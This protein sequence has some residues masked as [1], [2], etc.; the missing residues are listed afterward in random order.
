MPPG[1][2]ERAMG[3]DHRLPAWHTPPYRLSTLSG[4]KMNPTMRGTITLHPARRNKELRNREPQ[5]EPLGLKTRDCVLPA[6]FLGLV[7]G[8]SR[9]S[10]A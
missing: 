1:G 2:R 5:E 8:E 3:T 9:W 4:E 7:N 10:S 6:Y